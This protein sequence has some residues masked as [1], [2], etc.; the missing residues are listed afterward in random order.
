MDD[1]YDK[2]TGYN[3]KLKSRARDLRKQMT[4]QEKTLWYNYLKT[5]PIHFYRQ[6]SIGIYIADFYCAKAK[7]VVEIDGK[8]HYEKGAIG[9]DANR[10]QL[11]KKYGIE[12]IRF[13]NEEVT[14]HFESVCRMIDKKVKERIAE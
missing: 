14:N 1:K 11:F 7:L 10:T 4:P 2:F 9:Y 3:S 6:R 12:V 13:T 5:Y 8:Q